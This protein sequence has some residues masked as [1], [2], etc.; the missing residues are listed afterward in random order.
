MGE[1]GMA[2]FVASSRG[3]S[4]AAVGRCRTCAH[5]RN[6]PAFIEREIKGL[7]TMSSGHASVRG[8]DGLCLR[9]DRYL[10]AEAGCDDHTATVAQIATR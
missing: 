7:A 3:S 2:R 9:H 8:D 1:G 5:F 4:P 10:S 6:D